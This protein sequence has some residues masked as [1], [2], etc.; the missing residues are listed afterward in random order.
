MCVNQNYYELYLKLLAFVLAISCLAEGCCRLLNKLEYLGWWQMD[1]KS[2][3]HTLEVEC[4]QYLKHFG[5][6]RFNFVR[7]IAE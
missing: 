4:N 5:S 2:I 1:S 7:D 3:I 6:N